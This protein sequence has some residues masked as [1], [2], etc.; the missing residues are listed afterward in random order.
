MNCGA[1]KAWT[2]KDSPLKKYGFGLCAVEP[3][4]ALRSART[5]SARRAC[6][7]GRF[8]MAS[9]ETLAKREAALGERV[10]AE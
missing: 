2:F 1:C 4:H 6:I 5:T 8:V 10:C 7:N 3:D 9:P